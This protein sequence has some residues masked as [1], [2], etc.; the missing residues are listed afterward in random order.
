MRAGGVILYPTDTVWGIGCD[1]TNEEAVAKVY[2]IK[3]REEAKSMILLVDSISKVSNYVDEMPDL[4]WDIIELSEKP[5]T[6][7]YDK[8]RSL[9]KS[10][11]ADDESIAIRV[12]KEP[13]SQSLC[14]R[15]KIP[16]VSTSANISG[17]PTPQCFSE[18]SK[19]IKAAVDYIVDH[20][21]KE[22]TK[23]QA[24]SI[25]KLGASG[26]VKIIRE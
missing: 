17:Q 22:T 9:P 12:T 16:V 13:F 21:Q 4:A 14:Q 20:R 25:I 19:E 1:A 3:Q 24:S 23:A 2:A 5:I 18:I 8:S 26:L 15:M 7:I 11:C 10:L 6:I